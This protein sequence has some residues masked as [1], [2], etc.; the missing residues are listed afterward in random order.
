MGAMSDYICS[1]YVHASAENTKRT[2]SIMF[3]L[4]YDSLLSGNMEVFSGF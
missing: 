1:D 3:Y 4:G 2:Y